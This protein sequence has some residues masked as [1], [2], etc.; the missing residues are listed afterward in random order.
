MSDLI[1][2]L[3]GQGEKEYQDAVN[4]KKHKPTQK[5]NIKQNKPNQN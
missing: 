1:S 2:R 3:F 4:K 5:Q